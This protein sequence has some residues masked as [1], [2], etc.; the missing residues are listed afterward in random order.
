MSLLA[1]ALV[2]GV[3]AAGLVL[4]GVALAA[5]GDEL[6]ARTGLGRM[7]IGLL[8]VAVATSLPEVATD[9]TAARAD[10]PDL[11]VADLFGSS[12]ANVAILAIID[13]RVRGRVWPAVELGQAR[14]AAVAMVLT[15]VVVLGI[16]TPP[17]IAVGW[18]GVDT[19]AVAGLWVAAVA[20]FRRLAGRPAHPDPS[21][22][23]EPT[24]ATEPTEPTEP[25]E[26]IELTEANE[27]AP[28]PRSVGWSEERRVP[29]RAVVG[30][31]LAAAL[32]IAVTAPAL[33]LSAKAIAVGSGV[34]Q[35]VVGV[36][37]LAV[38]TS[39]PELVASVAA[40]RIGAHDLAVGNLFGSNAVNMAVLVLVDAAYTRGPI[41]AAVQ[42][43]EAVA[44]VGAILLMALAVAA[45]VGGT[46]TRAR[47]LEPDAIVVLVAY[48][49]AL[50]AVA[51]STG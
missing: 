31:F 26:A 36:G 42:P 35:T 5:S 22:P 7:F 25:T 14:V 20:W 12:M 9:V 39:L 40:V 21:E 8:L 30:R 50:V 16:L 6:A 28:A 51:L 29:T 32:A 2:F 23:T 19:L 41:L 49:G 45:M 47:R 44:G 18:I 3:A 17:G 1:A 4:A 15:S 43:S 46:E 34:D 48:V 24:E 38:T 27:P 37:L 10:A 11:A 13:L 33:A